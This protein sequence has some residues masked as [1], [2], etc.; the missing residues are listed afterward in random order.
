[1]YAEIVGWGYAV[2]TRI[3]TNSDIEQLVDTSD[4]WI[5]TRTG[6]SE[7][8]IAGPKE[9]NVH[10]GDPRRAERATNRRLESQQGRSGDRRDVDT[11]LSDA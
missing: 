10:A 9:V 2:P 1:M 8:R 6:I 5:R 7:R 4:E 11:R 3:M